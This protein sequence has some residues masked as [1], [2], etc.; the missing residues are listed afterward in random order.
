MHNYGPHMSLE[1]KHLLFNQI[2]QE[3]IGNNPQLAKADFNQIRD[4]LSEVRT[5]AQSKMV[6]VNY[7]KSIPL[8]DPVIDTEKKEPAAYLIFT[9][10]LNIVIYFLFVHFE[11]IPPATEMDAE[12]GVYVFLNGIL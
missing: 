12:T 3:L 10:F 1:S 7:L 2:V 4:A 11:I 9:S 6:I 5:L 8:I